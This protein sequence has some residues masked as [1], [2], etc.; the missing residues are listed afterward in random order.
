MEIYMKKVCFL[1]CL[2]ALVNPALATEQSRTT[3]Q[4]DL[5]TVINDNTAGD[6]TPADVRGKFTDLSDSCVFID[7]GA[8]GVTF[9]PSGL[10]NTDATDVQEMGAD[11]DAAIDAAVAGGLPDQTGNSGKYLTT[12]G[13]AASWGTIS[14]VGDVTAA[15]SL[16]DNAVVRGDGGTK[17]VQT[18]SV[19]IDD[20][21]NVSGIGTLGSGAHTITSSSATALA[22]GPNGTTNPALTVDA[23]TS[24][25]ATGVSVTAAA[26]GSGVILAATGGT[27]ETLGLRSKGTGSIDMRTGSVSRLVVSTNTAT[28]TPTT[29]STA[30]LSRFSW[31]NAADTS[32]TAGTEAKGVIWDL[33]ST[34]QHASNT[35]VA[36]QREFLVMAPTYSFASSGGVITDAATMALTGPPIGGTNATL[37][38]AH[39]LYIPT[40]AL[41]NV[42][43][44]YGL[45]VA[46]PSGAG[47]I[48]AA[49]KATGDVLTTGKITSSATADLG[50]S[51]Q[52]ASNQACTTTCTSAAVVGFDATAGIVGPSDAS[53][54]QCLCA[55]AN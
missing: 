30:S 38:N 33:S 5:S 11:L 8:A 4:S 19:L 51:V 42:T 32:L 6:V 53:A 22:V 17:G 43:N 35:T 50:W 49:I 1:L 24:S 54:D 3:Y 12:N 36:L 37:T 40:V 18:S 7:D 28:F 44:G 20:S 55:G 45:S 34:R 21:N 46:A 52:S 39:G 25:A 9:D 2:L 26:S 16:T 10:S 29:S 23:S 31:N 14:A 48:N 47:T 15:S 41:S 27:N 13:S